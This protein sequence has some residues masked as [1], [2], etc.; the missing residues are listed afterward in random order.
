MSTDDCEDIWTD[1]LIWRVYNV[2]AIFTKDN[3]LARPDHN[4]YVVGMIY[5]E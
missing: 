1:I 3:V 5:W 4:N 2:E